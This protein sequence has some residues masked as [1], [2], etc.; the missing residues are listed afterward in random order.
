[1]PRQLCHYHQQQPPQLYGHASRLPRWPLHS[2]PVTRQNPGQRGVALPSHWLVVGL[3]LAAAWCTGGCAGSR[4]HRT[5]PTLTLDSLDGGRWR[6]ADEQGKVVVLQFFATFDGA[7]LPV[8]RE[9][10]EIHIQFRHRGVAVVGVAL[11]PGDGAQRRRVVEAFCAVN[12]LTFEVLLATPALANG[13]TDLGQI[14][15]I[16]ATIVF[17]QNGQPL[18]STTGLLN[19]QELT[20][21]LE[22]V[23]APEGQ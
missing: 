18:A 22:R 19:R 2:S 10:E 6:L 17:D 13:E 21:L 5:G 23:L 14:P 20:Q 12:Q 11:D 1:M 3:L 4:L 7:S 16:P 15:V 9:L 8:V